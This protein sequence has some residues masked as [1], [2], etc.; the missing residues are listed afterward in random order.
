MP[1]ISLDDLEQIPRWLDEG[2]TQRQIADLC[3]VTHKAIS[4]QCKRHGWKSKFAARQQRNAALLPLNQKE[5]ATCYAT[6]NL[7]DFDLDP[8]SKSGRSSQCKL[9]RT[10]VIV[11]WQAKNM[12]KVLSASRRWK[13][14][15]RAHTRAYA[16]QYHQSH[17]DERN[18]YLRDWY[19]R[20]PGMYKIYRQLRDARKRGASG[21]FTPEQLQAR[22]TF[23]GGRCYLCGCDWYALPKEDQTIDHVIPLAKGGSNWP[24]NLR[25]A[26]RSCN[27]KKGVRRA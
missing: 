3:G 9:C 7:G 27:S 17:K 11:K 14:N 22:I 20:N 23:Y 1:Q 4:Y 24:S 18:A 16:S 19:K 15:N 26:C 21:E 13:E 25:P 12:E 6:R 5:C 10:S 8:R 2:L